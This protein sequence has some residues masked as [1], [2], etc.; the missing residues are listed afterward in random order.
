[1]CYAYKTTARIQRDKNKILHIEKTNVCGCKCLNKQTKKRSEKQLSK[2][3]KLFPQE[4][5]TSISKVF[6][7][8]Q[9]DFEI[10]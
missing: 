7:L 8:F 6:F 5:C 9:N 10:E 4:D 2:K 3:S 1:M